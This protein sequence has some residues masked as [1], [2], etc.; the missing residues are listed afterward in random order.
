[1]ETTLKGTM[2]AMH[3]ATGSPFPLFSLS[4][5]ASWPVGKLGSFLFFILPNLFF[6][7]SRDVLRFSGKR[8]I[9]RDRVSPKRGLVVQPFCLSLNAFSAAAVYCLCP[10]KMHFPAD[11]WPF[12]KLDTYIPFFRT[13]FFLL[14]SDY[15]N[16]W[17]SFW[18]FL[19]AVK[20]MAQFPSAKGGKRAIWWCSI[21]G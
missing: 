21:L 6:L 18:Y 3:T 15:F 8:D 11:F 17:A 5:Q 10:T 12:E 2:R 14:K 9:F 16:L 7:W 13:T 4:F 19:L 20:S 1:M